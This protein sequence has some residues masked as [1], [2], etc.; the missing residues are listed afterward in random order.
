[1]KR[2]TMLMLAAA[3]TG[4][5]AGAGAQTAGSESE[6]FL[7]AVREADGDKVI[8]LE[9]KLGP[10]VINYRGHD[11]DTPLTAAMANRSIAFVRFLLSKGAD[12]NI[13]DKRGETALITAARSGYVEGIDLMLDSKADVDVPNRQGETALIV[14][15]QGR[16]GPAVKRLLQG[17]AN[18]D[19][20]DFAAGY[21]AR[22]Y[23]KRDTRNPEL[24]R[25]IESVKAGAKTAVG[26]SRN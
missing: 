12:P 16:F 25:L 7:K 11:G 20:R 19:K 17:G 5:A 10:S 15:V 4:A 6:A 2:W 1:M 3:L 9:S 24:L 26:P 13:A 18:A 8:A 22:E 14:A 23:A 21:S